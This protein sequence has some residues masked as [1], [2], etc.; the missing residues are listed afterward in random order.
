M[1]TNS[2]RRVFVPKWKKLAISQSAKV[3]DVDISSCYIENI[4]QFPTLKTMRSLTMNYCTITSLKGIKKQPNLRY[5]TANDSLIQN[6]GGFL[7]FPNLITISI[8]NTP[9]SEDPNSII[10]V[11]CVCPK[12]V[13]FNN[14]LIPNKY[15]EIAANLPDG[16]E[17]LINS[18]WN[19]HLPITQNEVDALLNVN[20]RFGISKS[21]HLTSDNDEDRFYRMIDD[22]QKRHDEMINHF[23][24][25][26]TEPT[27]HENNRINSSDEQSEIS[28][29]DL[30]ISAISSQ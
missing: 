28:F 11:L 26:L 19:L 27:F 18:G 30:E 15:R 25:S 7:S 24:E 21:T 29:S 12:I 5:F 22:I 17:E 16:I 3:G 1:I 6:F 9:L 8:I 20:E 10:S 14:R 2:R 4:K 23:R 13:K